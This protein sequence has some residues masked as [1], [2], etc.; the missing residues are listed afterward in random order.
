M[1]MSHFIPFNVGEKKVADLVRIFLTEIWKHHGIPSAITLDRDAWYTFAIG[2]CIVDTQGIN[3]KMS[4]LFHPYADGQM[5]RV[6]QT[7]KWYLRNYCN[8]EQDNGEKSLPM[9]VYTYNNSL[10]STVKM[11]P[12]FANYSYHRRINWPTAE[13]SRNCTHRQKC[14]LTIGCATCTRAHA[15]LIASFPWTPV[16]RTAYSHL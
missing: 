11:T 1:K 16:R 7:L 14:K 5:Q 6:S 10:H 9:A 8:H 13:P 3:S 15:Q 4:S 12:F 2:T